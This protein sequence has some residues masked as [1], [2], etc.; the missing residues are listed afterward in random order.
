LR[1]DLVV[2]YVSQ[3]ELES[4]LKSAG[5]RIYSDRLADV[6]AILQT[7]RDIGVATG[8]AQEAD[9]QAREIQSRLDADRMR[10]SGRPRPRTLLVFGRQPG[11]LQQLYAVGGRGFL[12]DLLG[13]AGGANLFADVTRESVA[14]FTRDAD[15]SRAR[16]RGGASGRPDAAG[17]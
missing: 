2:T 17:G 4:K 5:I 8:H 11:T 1:P 13:I 15:R 9:K 16:C 14:A 6:P 3:T 12:H 7:L 10:V